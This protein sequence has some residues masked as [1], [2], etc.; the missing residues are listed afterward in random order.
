MPGFMK[1]ICHGRRS[2]LCAALGLCSRA[3]GKLERYTW[4]Y[5]VHVPQENMQKRLVCKRLGH[6]WATLGHHW[7]SLRS[8]LALPWPSLDQPWLPFG[9]QSGAKFD[10]GVSPG[11]TTKY[12]Y[13]LH[14]EHVAL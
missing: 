12:Y 4:S 13:L 6:P 9:T 8:P 11:P 10:P 7:V 14:L 1:Y 3:L 5:E 2:P